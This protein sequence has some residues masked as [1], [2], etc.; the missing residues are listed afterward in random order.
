MS[1]P[2][3]DVINV[4]SECKVSKCEFLVAIEKVKN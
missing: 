2:K 4:L 3:T 1:L